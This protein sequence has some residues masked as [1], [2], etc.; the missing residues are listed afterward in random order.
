[1]H[2]VVLSLAQG[3][4][5]FTFMNGEQRFWRKWLWL[6]SRNCFAI[7]LDRLRKTYWRSH[8]E[9]P[10]IRPKFETVPPEYKSGSLPLRQKIEVNDTIEVC[11]S[12]FWSYFL[13]DSLMC[14]WTPVTSAAEVAESQRNCN[15]L[16]SVISIQNSES[17]EMMTQWI[18]WS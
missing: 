4:L 16:C 7:R 17:L 3:Q 1:M 6:I 12:L 18:F 2:D 9:C 13:A 5:Y 15:L 8:I 10:I 11:V 14:G